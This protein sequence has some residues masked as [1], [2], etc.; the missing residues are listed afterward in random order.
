MA[1]EAVNVAGPGS[2]AGAAGS[3]G[4]AGSGGVAAG[5]GGAGAGS[6]GVAAGRPRPVS[7][8]VR[9]GMLAPL[10]AGSCYTALV[11]IPFAGHTASVFAWTMAAPT[12]WLLGSGYAGSAVMLCLA[13][14]RR[15]WADARVTVYATSFFM[16]LMLADT[17]LGRHTLH[18]TGGPIIGFFAAWGWLLV[19]F[20]AMFIG[21]VVLAAQARTPGRR[22]PRAAEP[23]LFVAGPMLF[24]ATWLTA[25]GLVLTIAPSWSLHGWPWAVSRLDVRALGAWCLAYAL[26]TWL[27]RREGDLD[28]ARP[29]LAALV[30]TG[31]LGLA[32]LARYAGDLRD[33]P[34]TWLILL[35]LV[36]LLGMGATGYLVA[37]VTGEDEEST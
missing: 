25:L 26:A 32:G 21:L 5:S 11:L 9:L 29:G 23:P 18:L 4:A 22:T 16:V 17:L 1:P 19:H 10:I 20:A 37:P 35:V 15:R 13:L 30:V 12:A 28:R 6:G 27:S 14:R 31:L 2:G 33:D 36:T 8:A 24:A 34:A 3:S 7:E